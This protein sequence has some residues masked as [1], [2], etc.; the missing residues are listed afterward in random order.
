MQFDFTDVRY[1]HTDRFEPEL[2]NAPPVDYY[3]I[4]SWIWNGELTRDEISRQLDGFAERGILRIYILPESKEFRPNTMPTFMEP[5]YLTP[6][7]LELYKYAA[8]YALGSGMRL[9]LYDEAGWPSGAANGYVVQAHPELEARALGRRT[10]KMPAGTRYTPGEDVLSAFDET[11]RRIY[12]NHVSAAA[13]EI[14]EY[15]S[16]VNRSR[17]YGYPDMHLA[18]STDSFIEITHEAYRGILGDRFGEEGGIALMF[19]DEPEALMFT[20]NEEIAALY[21]ERHGV[22]F[23]D[24]LPQLFTHRGE[25]W[26][27]YRDICDEIFAKNYFLRLREWCRRHNILSGGHINCEDNLNNCQN[28]TFYYTMR[29]LRTFD[30]PGVD[31][32]WRQIFPGEPGRR[33]DGQSTCDNRFFPRYA[34]SA[35][36]Q[37][38]SYASLSESFAVYGSGLTYSQMRFVL[39]FQAIRGITIFNPMN[40]GYC[41]RDFLTALMRPS[42][43]EHLPG[44]GDISVFMKYMARLSYLLGIGEPAVDTAVYMPVRDMWY[45]GETADKAIASFESIGHTIE[46]TLGY[47]DV[48]DDD[49]LE[50]ADAADRLEGGVMRLG[51]AAYKRIYVPEYSAMPEAARDRLRRFGEGG[52]EVIYASSDDRDIVVPAPTANVEPACEMLRAMRRISPDGDIIYLFNESTEPYEGTVQLGEGYSEADLDRGVLIACEPLQRFT[53]ASGELKGFLPIAGEPRET[54]EYTEVYRAE[55]LRLR[56]LRRFVIGKHEL[57]SEMM[58]AEDID[59]LP[60]DWQTIFGSEFSG[61]ALYSHTLE[62]IGNLAGKR[63]RIELG[64]V[65]Y[66]CELFIDGVSLGVRCMAPFACDLPGDLLRNGSEISVRVSNTGANQFIST[67]FTKHWQTS[68]IGPYD[69]IT[70]NFEIESLAG[71]LYGPIRILAENYDA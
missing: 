68:Q 6:E 48:I 40:C 62:G 31:A 13:S 38:G 61:D 27:N 10:M 26:A 49:A 42:L 11:G 3:P 47:F 37:I 16:R 19:T 2:F 14:T 36:N 65:F 50:T 35:A 46:S 64:E 41:Y 71:G 34:S 56:P 70:R 12:K 28:S 9:W 7:F 58:D 18:A 60:G 25:V 24:C 22:P 63:C 17:S 51:L 5:G 15:Y 32:I 55:K 53:L 20:Y 45:G 23:A 8:E 54:A 59:T 29:L 21:E 57:Y 52:G 69:A 66:T 39:G 43:N 4:Y 44:A 67:D 30:V 1:C 33:R